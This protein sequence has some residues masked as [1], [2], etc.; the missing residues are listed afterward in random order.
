M[1]TYVCQS[2]FKRRY[3]YIL[4]TTPFSWEWWTIGTRTSF[5]HLLPW[6]ISFN[7]GVFLP[8]VTRSRDNHNALKHHLRIWNWPCA[9]SFCSNRYFLNYCNDHWFLSKNDASTNSFSEYEKIWL[10]IETQGIRQLYVLNFFAVRISDGGGTDKHMNLQGAMMELNMTVQT[11]NG[12]SFWHVEW[13]SYSELKVCVMRS[14]TMICGPVLHISF[15]V[16]RNC[17]GNMCHSWIFWYINKWALH[18]VDVKDA[19]SP[20]LVKHAILK[21]KRAS[22]RHN[23]LL[24]MFVMH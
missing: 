6:E 7:I 2:V 15:S 1:E 17:Y 5:D 16:I 21:S 13:K 20:K 23:L 9:A 10:V 8:A 3:E 18:E 22:F 19:L 12:R 4:R 11:R 14:R 24:P